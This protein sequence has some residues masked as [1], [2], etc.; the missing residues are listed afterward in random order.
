MINRKNGRLPI[1]RVLVVFSVLVLLLNGAIVAHRAFDSYK[2]SLEAGTAESERLLRI[3]ADHVEL[4]FLAVDVTLR[5][6]SERQ[7]FNALF[8]HNLQDDIQNNFTVW[9]NETPQIAAMLMTDEHGAIKMIY[10]KQGYKTWMEGKESL[11]NEGYFTTQ[12]DSDDPDLLYLAPRQSWIQDK[13]LIVMSRRISKLDGSFGGIVLAAIHN[14]YLIDFFQSLETGKRTKFAVIRD[15]NRSLINQLD[16]ADAEVLQSMINVQQPKADLESEEAPK[17]VYSTKVVGAE[18]PSLTEGAVRVYTYGYIPNLRLVIGLVSYGEDIFTGW[19]TDRMHD[20]AFLGMFGL[21]AIVIS[22]FAIT[23]ANQ[24]QRVQDSEQKA[25]MASQA[26]TEFLANMS[27]ELRTPLNAIIGFSEMLDA[28][29]FGKV[30]PK[31]QERIMDIHNCGSHLLE[32]INDIL[33]FS[34]GEAGM[35]DLRPEKVFLSKIVQT[36]LRMFSER[37]AAEGIQII[38]SVPEDLPPVFVDERKIKQVLIN[39]ISNAV[40]FTP[41]Q[42]KVS[43]RASIDDEKNIRIAVEDTGIGMD[44]EDIPRAMSVFGQV[45]KDPKYGGTGLGLPL[46]KMLMDLHGGKMEITSKKNVGT[47]VA[48]TIPATRI[49]WQNPKTLARDTTTPPANA[50]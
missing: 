14:S 7:Y 39:L 43:I 35:M 17:H 24:M 47:T 9:V 45:H 37:A 4:T 29:Y 40:K 11:E 2:K 15:D 18:G 44:E 30:N 50:A 33:E 36:T 12:R 28:G 31:Q 8:G 46:C 48:I 21:F 23:M 27:H 13:D 6:A 16:E 26:K 1:V 22:F 32:L 3:L 42:G 49:F 34:K 5:R 38:E 25:V 20:I 41:K 10:R 19:H